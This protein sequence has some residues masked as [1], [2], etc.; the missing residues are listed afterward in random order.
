[1]PG[2]AVAVIAKLLA[3]LSLIVLLWQDNK[4]VPDIAVKGAV[5]GV[6]DVA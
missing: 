6:K 1:M 5:D 4:D 2:F 3:L